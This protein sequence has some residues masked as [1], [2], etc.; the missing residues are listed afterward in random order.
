MFATVRNGNKNI[1]YN[2]INKKKKFNYITYYY[3]NQISSR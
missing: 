2:V 1:R 3:A